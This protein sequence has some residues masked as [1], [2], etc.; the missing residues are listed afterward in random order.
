[1][2]KKKELA[3][4]TVIITVGKICTQFMSFLLL[5]LYTSVLTTGEYGTVDLLMTYQQLIGYIVFFQIE[6]AIFRFLIEVRGDKKKS[7]EIVASCSFFA[8]IQMIVLGIGLYIISHIFTI[9]YIWYL[10]FYI[11]AAILSGLMLQVAR[12]IGNNMVYTI[13]SFISAIGA[14]LLNILFLVV[15]GWGIRGMLLAYIIGNLLGA[16]YVFIILRVYQLCSIKQINRRALKKCLDYSIPLVP[17]ALSWWIMSVSDRTIVSFFL[18]TASNG[19]LTV[20]NKFPSAYSAFYTVFNLSWTESAS[21]HLN[22]EDHEEF[23]SSVISKVCRLFSALAIGIIAVLP[24]IFNI[25][26]NK[27]FF[28]S[29]Y[30]IPIYMLSSLFQVIQGMYSVIY[31]ALKKTK[32]IAKTTVVAA[33]I[34]LTI[35]I[36]LIK[37]IG[38]YAASLSTLI[39]YAFITVWRYLDLKKYMNIHFDYKAFISALG[40][41]ICISIGYYS[42]NVKLQLIMLVLAIVYSAYSNRDILLMLLNGPQNIKNILTGKTQ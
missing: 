42:M 21:L 7:A 38:L 2:D 39:S 19:L 37:Y 15:L 36:V 23:F 12:G 16:I 1:M 6:Q 27:K 5:P 33:I 11:I 41:Y 31:V 8:I 14:I 40:V 13:G 9:K 17:N 34:N 26:V 29:Y 35:N 20:A 18:G 22:D 28:D 25:I 10:F 4:N 30:Q 24:F 32:E 3:K